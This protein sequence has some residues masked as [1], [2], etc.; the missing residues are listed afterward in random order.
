[1]SLSNNTK[2]TVLIFPVKDCCD[3]N[4]NAFS[5]TTQPESVLDKWYLVY[6]I[7]AVTEKH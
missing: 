4:V 7:A 3:L 2:Y 6:Y 5:G 1:M